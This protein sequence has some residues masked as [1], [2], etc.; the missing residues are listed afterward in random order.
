MAV[1]SESGF[2]IGGPLLASQ[3][4]I[5]LRRASVQCGLKVVNIVV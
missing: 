2:N 5:N 3:H 1:R 4:R